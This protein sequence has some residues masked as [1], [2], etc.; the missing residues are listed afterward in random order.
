MNKFSIFLLSIMILLGCNG[1]NNKPQPPTTSLDTAIFTKTIYKVYIE[2]SASMDGYVNGVSEFKDA[3]GS[4]ISD[5]SI[6]GQID[7]MNF[8]FVNNKSIKFDGDISNF[9]KSIDLPNF[10]AFRK[11]GGDSGTT[12]I[13]KLLGVVLKNTSED[14]VSI[15]ASDFIFSPGKGK[16]AN[17]YLSTQRDEIKILVA[18][19]LTKY[20]D[21]AVLIYQLE[22]GFDGCCYN[23]VDAPQK[24]KGQRPYYFWIIGKTKHLSNLRKICPDVKFKGGGV[25]NSIAIINQ[26]TPV[27]YA[28]QYGSGNFKP[29]K[30]DA[31][32]SITNAQKDIKGVG[33]KKLRFNINVDFSSLPINDSY[34]LDADN[35]YL[36]DKDYSIEIHKSNIVGYSHIL[37]LSTPIVKPTILSIKLKNQR[38]CWVDELNDYIGTNI[39]DINQSSKTFGIKYLIDGVYEAFA[40]DDAYC[41]DIKVKV[42]QKK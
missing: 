21:H 20:T 15:L 3:F 23:I 10:Q 25:K 36:N 4:F 19:H 1:G 32:K 6:S 30:R 16:N 7:S 27:K 34:L 39:N 41:A 18:K 13:S 29:D 40:K 37:K 28:I 42:N 33:E 24:F 11:K 5:I 26:G 9:I 8:Y 2:N 22:S 38:P 12:D 14:D 17:Q 35:Y 31:Q